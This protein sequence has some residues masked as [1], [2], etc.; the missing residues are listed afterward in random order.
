MDVLFHS[1]S[2]SAE[3]P[4]Q[5]EMAPVSCSEEVG[6]NPKWPHLSLFIHSPLL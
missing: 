4:N 5:Q 6:F 1:S 3:F 2:A